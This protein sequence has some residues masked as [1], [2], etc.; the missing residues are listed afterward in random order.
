MSWRAACC[1]VSFLA[2]AACTTL[3]ERTAMPTGGAEHA[4]RRIVVA[5]P[6]ESGTNAALL[7]A[8]EVRY[9][10]RRGYSVSPG[11]ERVLQ[12]LAREYE[13][14]RVDGWP[15]ASLEVYCEVYELPPDAQVEPLLERLARDPRIAI[16]QPMNLF[17]TL[18]GRYDDTYVDLQ[19]AVLSMDVES[20]HQVATGRGV[21]VAV[22]DSGVDVRHPDLR[23][24]VSVSSNLVDGSPMPRDGEI[25]G[26]AVAGIIASS[27]NNAEGIVGIA[28]EASI[29]TLRACWSSSEG[30]P[31][32]I[33]STFSLAKALELA[34][35]LRPSVINLSLAGPSDPLLPQLL[36]RV[37]ERGLVGVTGRPDS[38]YGNAGFPA[39]LPG[40]L[41]VQ[42]RETPRSGGWAHV[43]SAPGEEILTTVPSAS[44][45]FLSGGSL[46]AAHVSGVVALLLEKRPEMN[47]TEITSLLRETATGATGPQ[48]VNACHALAKL[49]GLTACA[50]DNRI[51]SL[52]D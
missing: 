21:T 26:T 31:K 33:C 11:V 2:A 10:R 32:A 45:A 34:L 18:A 15:I 46:A 30:R 48:S 25:H 38:L 40:V 50:Q 19:S 22:V 27:A 29:A 12:Q 9:Q 6:Q 36:T 14:S 51:V 35:S 16:A 4:A 28:P 1:L 44:Y 41:V 42:Q 39:S 49:T 13:F 52:A 47:A 8:P 3:P 17:E 37:L 43:L 5:V 24:R 7:G 23:D 20:A